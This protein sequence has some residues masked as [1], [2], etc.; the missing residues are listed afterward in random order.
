MI[1]ILL[2]V[3]NGV[4]YMDESV[5]SVLNQT[6]KDWELLIGVNGHPPNSDVYRK[7]FEYVKKD[8]LGRIKVFDLHKIKGKVDTLHEL[9][10]YTTF[11]WVALIDVDDI[12]IKNKLLKQSSFMNDYDV[13]GT[14]AHY[15][16]DN[17]GIP[18][19]PLYDISRMNFVNAN[20]II[21]SSVLLKKQLCY[22]DKS[23]EGIEDY[24][25]WL[26]LRKEKKTF[27]NLPDILVRHRIH[28]TSQF[29]TQNHDTKMNKLK[30]IYK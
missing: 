12:W 30:T 22:W 16:G 19:I 8:V 15:I 27:Y 23:Y 25:L 6:Y 17:N 5:L 9:L 21:N 18:L 13:I 20:P 14:H 24:E 26:R 4:E 11:D 3:Y 7:A 1:S 29:N 10:K 2:P 28:N